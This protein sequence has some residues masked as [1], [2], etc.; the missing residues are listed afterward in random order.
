MFNFILSFPLSFQVLATAPDPSPQEK[1]FQSLATNQMQV[2]REHEDGSESSDL[3]PWW[4]RPFLSQALAYRVNESKD[5]TNEKCN[6][7]I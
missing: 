2:L 3:Y 7:E 1:F 4:V 6:S 5:A